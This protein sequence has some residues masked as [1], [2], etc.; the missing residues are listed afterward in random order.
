MP[1]NRRELLAGAGSLAAGAALRSVGGHLPIGISDLTAP[2]ANS[3]FPR[4]SD[5]AI[6][7]DVTYINS[8]YTHPMP[9]AVAKK[10][11]EPDTAGDEKTVASRSFFQTVALVVGS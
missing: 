11:R 7:A 2:Y 6:P 5:F 8:A 4:R 1:M 3:L 9:V 10:T